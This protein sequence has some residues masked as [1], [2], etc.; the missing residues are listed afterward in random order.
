MPVFYLEPRADALNDPSW[1][2]SYL[3]EGCFTSRKDVGLRLCLRECALQ[4]WGRNQEIGGH[5]SG[6]VDRPFVM[7]PAKHHQLQAGQIV[8]R[9]SLRKNSDQVRKSYRC[10]RAQRWKALCWRDRSDRHG[11]QAA[12]FQIAVKSRRHRICDLVPG[13]RRY[14]DHHGLV[15][16]RPD[17]YCLRPA[18][19]TEM[20]T[21][22]VKWFNPAKGYGFIQ[23]AGGGRDVF[24]HISAV[25]RAGL[26]S[27]NDGQ[28]V[29]FEIESNRG[30]ESAVNLKIKWPLCQ[31]NQPSL[32]RQ[33]VEPVVRAAHSRPSGRGS[34]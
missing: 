29:E 28:T 3:K 31:R 20:A 30:K 8:A 27:L 24:V 6:S 12:A 23:A 1:D 25:E 14:A 34:R 32:P 4:T 7:D 17:N 18:L 13:R 15:V 5:A 33:N 26:N 9:N 19:E 22:T 21:G 10:L 11:R 2:T 16:L